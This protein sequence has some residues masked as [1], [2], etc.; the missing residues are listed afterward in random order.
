MTTET[1]WHA[2]VAAYNSA[3]AYIAKVALQATRY[4]A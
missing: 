2:G 3:P 1:G 4:G